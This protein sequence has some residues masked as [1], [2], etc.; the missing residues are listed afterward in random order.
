M[1][2][3][4]EPHNRPNHQSA[5]QQKMCWITSSFCF[6]IADKRFFSATRLFWFWLSDVDIMP[7]VSDNI[8]KVFEVRKWFTFFFIDNFFARHPKLSNLA[9]SNLANAVSSSC[10]LIGSCV[11]SRKR[12]WLALMRCDGTQSLHNSIFNSPYVIKR[13]SMT[14]LMM[15]LKFII[16]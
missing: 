15:S 6:A 3:T 7:F 5:D 14:S 9:E 16:K 8:L 2:A 4:T 1:Q 10:E 12:F 13:H 11:L